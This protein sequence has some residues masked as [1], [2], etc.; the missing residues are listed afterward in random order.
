MPRLLL[1]AACALCVRALFGLGS[2]AASRYSEQA[3]KGLS[4]AATADCAARLPALQAAHAAAQEAEAA[5]TAASAL[6]PPL[7]DT[8]LALGRC[9]PLPNATHAL[10]R[11]L[12]LTALSPLGEDL[13]TSVDLLEVLGLRQ[14]MNTMEGL[15]ASQAYLERAARALNRELKALRK[16]AGNSSSGGGGSSPSPEL[17]RTEERLAGVHRLLLTTYQLQGALD[18]AIGVGRKALEFYQSVD[19]GNGPDATEAANALAVALASAGALEEAEQIA[20]E[21]H[22]AH[23][24]HKRPSEQ[25]L[26]NLQSTGCA[27]LVRAQR[28]EEAVYLCAEAL[29]SAEKLEGPESFMVG[30]LHA[31]IAHAYL[32]MKNARSALEAGLR[33]MPIL[34]ERTGDGSRPTA[35]LA[36]TLKNAMELLGDKTAWENVDQ[37]VTAATTVLARLPKSSEL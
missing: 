3:T 30:K 18:K 15:N 7:A 27:T 36:I 21:A 13:V 29:A 17:R 28:T 23:S 11:A 16:A 22:Q 2:S 33:G 12:N 34:R 25:L 14:D 20:R 9:L 35:N 4:L 37:L 5:G 8:L 1:L 32:T 24:A 6:S 10:T 19:G 31:Y 26:L